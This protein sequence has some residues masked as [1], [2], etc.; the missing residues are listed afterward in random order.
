ML[1]ACRVQEQEFIAA[2]VTVGEGEAMPASMEEE[3][4]YHVGLGAGQPPL[5]VY[6]DQPDDEM[7]GT[8][9]NSEVA[10]VTP[11]VTIS[12]QEAARRLD[13]DFAH[14]HPD[15]ANRWDASLLAATSN[16]G[17]FDAK[18]VLA[19]MEPVLEPTRSG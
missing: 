12:F 10:R 5:D 19:R 7:S 18:D 2:L 8:G 13:P 14:L 11:I 1:D 16:L 4:L 17:V 15:P 9:S 6:L 3:T